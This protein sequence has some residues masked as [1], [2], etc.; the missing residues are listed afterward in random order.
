MS[1]NRSLPVIVLTTVLGVSGCQS[2]SWFGG[3]ADTA[4]RPGTLGALSPVT[5]PAGDSEPAV[6]SLDAVIASY[7]SLLP[8]I[9]DP[10]EQVAVRHRL[11]DLEFQRAEQAFAERA[12]G[13][14]AGA[15]GAYQRLLADYPGRP[16]N[17]QILYQL[18]RARELRGETGPQLHALTDLVN[19]YPQSRYWPEAQ[20][21]RGDLLF[22][23]G[24]YAEAEAAFMAVA[25]ASGADPSLTTNAWYMAG[26]SQFKQGHYRPALGSFVQVLDRVMPAGENASAAQDTLLTDLFRVF[27]LSLSYLQGADTLRDLFLETG[28]RAYEPTVYARYSELLVAR[29]RYTDAIAALETFNEAHPGSPWAPRYDQRILDILA[30]AGFDQALPER[31]ARFVRRYGIQGDYWANADPATRDFILSRLEPLIPELADRHYLLASRARTDAERR[32]HYRAAAGYYHAFATTFPGH[33]RTPERLFLLAEAEL[34]LEEWPAA[35]QAFEQVAYGFAY[36]DGTPERAA[37]AGYASVLAFRSYAETWRELPPADRRELEDQQQ[38]NRL[39]F[40][41]AFPDDPRAPDV[42]A[43]ALQRE[44]ERDHWE[45]TVVMAERLVAWQPPPDPERVT[46]ALRLSG[47]ALFELARYGEAESAYRQALSRLPGN[48]ER[49][50]EIRRNLAAAVYRQGDVAATAG[51]TSE[52]VRHY[53]RV[54]EVM[55][56]SELHANAQY[57]A[58][59]LL[60]EAGDWPSAIGVLTD[61]RARFPAHPLIDTVPAKLALAY[62]ETGQWALAGDEVSRLSELAQSPEEQRENLSIAAGLYDRSGDTDR[63]IDA[64]RRYANRYPEP[65]PAYLEAAHR[66]AE[67]YQARG[68]IPRRNYWLEKQMVRVERLGDDAD[69][70]MRYLAASAAA[71]LAREALARYQGIRLTL[72]LDRS[73]VA[74]TEALEAAVTAY[75]RMAAF[76]VAELASEAGYQIADIYARLARDLMDSE[77]PPGLNELE[78]EQYELLLE[79]QAYPFEDNA[80]DIHEQNIRKAQQGIYDEWVRRSYE[81]LRRLLPGRYD[82]TE[83]RPEVVDELG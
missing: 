19:R 23:A 70:R 72:P 57:D 26:W 8:L 59:G 44:F 45:D 11:A 61:F 76:G 10:R 15:I 50:P 71:T 36:T 60:I 1:G 3:E 17:D 77:R 53:L 13:D 67:L 35:I 51:Q 21:R 2:L 41:N 7:R 49:V 65:V 20:F 12:E 39:R 52:A 56:G 4:A 68:D 32:R 83:I 42:F 55:P 79:E 64:W 74:K 58:A 6:V 28:P 78:L 80:I 69:D 14:L 24:R 38:L 66:L 27:G 62:R 33:P 16:D 9:D 18:A 43:I 37:E 40:A 47:H 5:V 75:Q 46:E 25:R 81:A 63:A 29:E 34:A 30:E 48:D 22:G 31:K 54:A 73:M 82:K